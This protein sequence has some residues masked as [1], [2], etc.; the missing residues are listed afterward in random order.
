MQETRVLRFE[1]EDEYLEWESENDNTVYGIEVL[2]RSKMFTIIQTDLDALEKEHLILDLD[3]P[4]NPM[5]ELT[6][7]LLSESK[8]LIHH[9]NWAFIGDYEQ[10]QK[11]FVEI[12]ILIKP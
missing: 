3:N 2:G 7:K 8:Q 4:Q 6:I 10:H 11:R 9:S 5:V 12:E 1:N